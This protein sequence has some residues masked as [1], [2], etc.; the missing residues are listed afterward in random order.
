MKIKDHTHNSKQEHSRIREDKA[1]YK[2]NESSR[3]GNENLI[4][5][6]TVRSAK[7]VIITVFGVT[8]SLVGMV[9]L[10][11]PGP[12]LLMILIGLIVLSGE[13][14]WARSWLKRVKQTA[15]DMGV[16][17]QAQK[18]YR[19]LFKHHKQS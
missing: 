10:V 14:A 13:F 11:T 6:K 16:E 1:N 17:Q 7:R 3:L 4:W 9:M 2:Q 19:R 15:R 12:G 5:D 18:W 8:I